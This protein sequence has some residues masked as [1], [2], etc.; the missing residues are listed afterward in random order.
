VGGKPCLL[1][2]PRA[3]PRPAFRRVARQRAAGSRS[4]WYASHFADYQKTYGAIGGVMVALL[5]FYFTSLAIL[6]GAQLDATIERASPDDQPAAV[7]V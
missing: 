4:E 1:L 5:W 3:L 2:F 6:I 7:G